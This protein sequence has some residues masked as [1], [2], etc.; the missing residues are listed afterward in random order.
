MGGRTE[1]AP[2]RSLKRKKKGGMQ[3]RWEEMMIIST[4][5]ISGM[6]NVNIKSLLKK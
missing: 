5:I 6:D 4:D 3:M 1:H 2:H